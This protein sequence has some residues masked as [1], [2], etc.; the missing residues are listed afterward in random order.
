MNGNL[1]GT[2]FRLLW[3]LASHPGHMCGQR[4]PASRALASRRET[5]AG[6]IA[7]PIQRLQRELGGGGRGFPTATVS[8]LA[9]RLD[10]G[11]PPNRTMEVRS[12]PAAQ[13]E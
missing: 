8:G 9:R 12:R 6:W 4:E 10:V 13:P 5:A 7:L 11:M 1:T 2:E 3:F